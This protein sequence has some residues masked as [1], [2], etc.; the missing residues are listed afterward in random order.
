MTNESAAA[1]H[2]ADRRLG[3]A[4]AT[5]VVLETI[6]AFLADSDTIGLLWWLVLAVAAVGVTVLLAAA[7]QARAEGLSTYAVVRKGIDRRHR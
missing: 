5:L 7:L 2:A 4:A 1:D 3:L 6:L